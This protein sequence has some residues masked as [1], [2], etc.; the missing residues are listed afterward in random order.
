MTETLKNIYP[1]TIARVGTAFRNKLFGQSPFPDNPDIF[2]D[3]LDSQG[4]AAGLPEYLVD[5]ARLERAA[6]VAGKAVISGPFGK[7]RTSLNPS[8]QLVRTSW[9]ILPFFREEEPG[10]P[11]AMSQEEPV[12]VWKDPK[13]SSVKVRRASSE[14]LLI[15]K[16][17]AEEID[18]KTLSALGEIPL[19]V[20]YN[21]LNR[22]VEEGLL[23]RPP[24]AIRRPETW[25]SDLQL[26]EE[27]FL[28]SDF[29]TLQWHV[30]Q[31]CD[32][33]CKHCYDRSDRESM[34]LEAAYAVLEDFD[35]FCNSRN[36]RGCIS[37]T[38]GNPLL[39]PHFISLYRRASEYGFG[40]SI[41]GNPT[42]EEQLEEVIAIR[43]PDHFQVSLEGLR[44]LNDSMRGTG[45][46]DR[47]IEFLGV[48]KS[49]GV[50]SMVMLTLTAENIDQIIPLADALREKTDVFHFNRLSMTGEGASL[51]LPS[52]ERFGSFLEGYL[53]AAKLNP[54]LGMKESLLNTCLYK[55]G[56]HIFG[57]CTGFGCGAAF[58]F[59]A[60]LPDG[61]VH[62][63]R[64]F[65]SV[66][67]NL[68]E[69]S[70][71]E[72][73]CSEVAEHYRERLPGCRDC[74]LCHV[75]GGCLAVV[76]GL[77]SDDRPD[78]DPYC[79]FETT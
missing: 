44:D 3:V 28:S 47:T 34:P 2:P 76:K 8:I 71:D 31:S 13:T 41:L 5:L 69:Q 16:M 29:F 26:R 40:L 46:Y 43:K 68:R 51:A 38:G 65:P 58:N 79:F 36:V 25:A 33:H 56:E 42:S 57:G 52:R 78:R 63:C 23:L 30:T 18:A 9:D 49:L 10:K 73:Y 39:Y 32:L 72:V 70:I 75:C 22:V 20:I 55:K 50:Y 14:S 1:R 12:L 24:S 66:I 15:L 6:F 74:P 7:G 62:A 11:P 54:V 67:G 35:R 21:A 77:G 4:K 17:V 45:H 53:A 27:V 60:L 37:F 48:L 59:I 19:S 64:K 61:E